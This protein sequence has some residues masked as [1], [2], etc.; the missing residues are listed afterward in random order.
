MVTKKIKLL[1]EYNN[2]DAILN[3][4]DIDKVYLHFESLTEM[5][6]QNKLNEVNRPI[7]KINYKGKSIYR[8]F[9]QGSQFGVTKNEIGILKKDLNTLGIKKNEVVE[10][11]ISFAGFWGLFFYYWNNPKQD[12]RFAM[13]S[14]VF[15][16][17]LS[18]FL[19]LFVN[20]VYDWLD[21]MFHFFR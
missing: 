6:F 17:V 10:V 18:F 16:I 11:K 20:F 14:A 4:S 1:E 19:G 2:G 3:D 15:A 5:E 21:S 9:K 13:R 12:I 7:V 8:K